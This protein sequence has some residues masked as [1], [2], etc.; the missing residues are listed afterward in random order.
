MWLQWQL[1][2]NHGINNK[3]ARFS[4]PREI[5]S[6]LIETSIPQRPD[7]STE[8]LAHYRMHFDVINELQR[9]LQQ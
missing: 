2:F 6:L 5:Q 3:L 4:T 9:P 8:I 1:L 7:F